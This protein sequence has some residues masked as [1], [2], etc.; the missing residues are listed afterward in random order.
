MKNSLNVNISGTMGPIETFKKG[1]LF[2]S[3]RSIRWAMVRFSISPAKTRKW[4]FLQ[5]IIKTLFLDGEHENMLCSAKFENLL[6][7]RLLLPWGPCPWQRLPWSRVLSQGF[8]RRKPQPSNSLRSRDICNFM[9][10]FNFSYIAVAMGA[11]SMATVARNTR[12][13]PLL[14]TPPVPAL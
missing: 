3:R 4:A 11:I 13:D 6:Y 14:P 7:P 12:P 10:K 5:K 2:V 8:Q 9:K 1:K